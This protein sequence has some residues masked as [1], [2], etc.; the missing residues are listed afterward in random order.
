MPQTG[1]V[2]Y[3]E[4]SPATVKRMESAPVEP[5]PA[6]SAA[7]EAAQPASAQAGTKT[8]VTETSGGFS[9]IV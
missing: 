6:A 2:A 4:P 9:L 7:S 8:P 5:S 3:Q 1:D